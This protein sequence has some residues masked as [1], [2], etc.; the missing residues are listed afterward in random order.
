M[1]VLTDK[2]F[3]GVC[4][5]LAI[6]ERLMGGFWSDAD[7]VGIHRTWR[8]DDLLLSLDHYVI[9]EP[10]GQPD[11][12]RIHDHPARDIRSGTCG[13]AVDALV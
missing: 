11:P 7:Y 3:R 4:E 6:E 13:V 2:A 5:Q 1:D 10:D 12:V 9:I 8:N